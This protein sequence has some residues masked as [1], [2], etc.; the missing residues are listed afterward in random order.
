M[1]TLLSFQNLFK[2]CV[3]FLCSQQVEWKPQLIE[4]PSQTQLDYT[5]TNLAGGP[6]PHSPFDSQYRET[7]LK[8]SDAFLLP[9]APC[10]A[11]ALGWGYLA[12]YEISSFFSLLPHLRGAC[13]LDSWPRWAWSRCLPSGRGWGRT[14]WRTS[15]FFRQPSTHWRSC[16]SLEK[17]ILH[18]VLGL[19][20]EKTCPDPLC[21]SHSHPRRS[22]WEVWGWS[23]WLGW[24]PLPLSL[25]CVYPS[26]CCV[27]GWRGRPSLREENRSS[28]KG[29]Q[30]AV[31]P[32]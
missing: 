22:R 15:P 14:T 16:E 25:F 3:V 31:F 5:V 30:E 23:G 13:L 32:C 8:V 12:G 19:E 6:K 29:I 2:Q 26:W 1:L 27:L 9:E 4:V 24:C 21:G 11:V 20:C 7:T 17:G 18:P 28:V 10:R